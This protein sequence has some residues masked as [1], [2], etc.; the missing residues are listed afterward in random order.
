MRAVRFR[1]RLRTGLILVGVMAIPLSF[2]NNATRRFRYCWRQ[3]AIFAS[4][5]Q[6]F[7]AIA[8]NNKRVVHAEEAAVAYGGR[9]WLYRWESLRFW[10]PYELIES[11]PYNR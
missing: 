3:Q 7:W 4:H 1:L 11:H 5:E 2:A 8:S 9:K 10:E 6:K